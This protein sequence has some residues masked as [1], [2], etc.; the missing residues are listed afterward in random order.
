L[1]AER[2]A[3]I[4]EARWSSKTKRTE[5]YEL[6]KKCLRYF[7]FPRLETEDADDLV[8]VCA[9]ADLV[10]F[11]SQRMFL[12]DFGLKEKDS[13]DYA[14]FMSYAIEP[15]FWA[16]IAT[17]ILTNTGH[18]D[19]TRGRGSSSQGD[20]NE[21]LFHIET[22]KPF[23]QEQEGRIKLVL[24]Y[25]RL[26]N[27][28]EWTMRIGGGAYGPW[29]RHGGARA[30]F[31]AAVEKALQGG[32]LGA[33]ALLAAAKEAGVKINRSAALKLLKGYV[34]DEDIPIRQVEDGYA[35]RKKR[36]K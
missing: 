4:C 31:R 9:G 13:D 32:P 23:D 6:I 35:L 25:S 17:L 29:E 20:L 34:D 28:G 30:D 16:G 7:E 33:N 2:L 36:R 5:V 11:D 15:L 27:R 3:D 26:G 18:N 24:D 19:Q 12:S 21:L 8:K 1:Y 22:V 10:V 14:E